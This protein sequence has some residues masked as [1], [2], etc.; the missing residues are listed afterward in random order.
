M[1]FNNIIYLLTLG[2]SFLAMPAFA[3]GAHQDPV[4]PILLGLVILF[5]GAKIG[6]YIAEKI[7]QPAV[8]GELVMG[9]IFGNLVL[10]NYDGLNFI[11]E[12]EVFSIMAGIGVVLLLF[13]VGLESSVAGLLKV[14]VT[15]TIVAIIGVVLPFFFGFFASEFFLADKSVYVHTFIGATLCATS[16]GITARV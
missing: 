6:G 2:L 14:G 3:A 11:N 7:H 8:L 15:A 13:E 10:L 1:K 12:G 16:V 5:T 4:A 9:V